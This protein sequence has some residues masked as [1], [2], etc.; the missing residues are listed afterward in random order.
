MSI[1]A[2]GVIDVL[3]EDGYAGWIRLPHHICKGLGKAFPSAGQIDPAM[4]Q[5]SFK[6]RIFYGRPLPAKSP[7]TPN[8]ILSSLYSKPSETMLE[9]D[10]CLIERVFYGKIPFVEAVEV[11]VI[12][13]ELESKTLLVSHLAMEGLA[14]SLSGVQVLIRSVSPASDDL[15][16]IGPQTRIIM[17]HQETPAIEFANKPLIGMLEDP[18]SSLD[19]AYNRLYEMVCYP[20]MHR[21]LLQGLPIGIPN[22]VILSGPPGVGKTHLVRRLAEA[23][24]VPALPVD[25]SN[26]MASGLGESESNLAKAFSDAISLADSNSTGMAILFLDEL[27]AIG[28]KREGASAVKARIVAQ[29]L[30]LM[31]G[32]ESVRRRNVVIIGATNRPNALDPALRRPGRFDREIIID[33]PTAMERHSL[34]GALAANIGKEESLDLE[35]ISKATIGYV[36]ADLSAL[37]REAVLIAYKENGKHLRLSTEH[38]IRAMRLVGPSLNRDYRVNLDPSL[39]LDSIGGYEDIKTRLQRWV[40]GPLKDPERYRLLG[41]GPPRGIL[42]HGPPGCSKTTFAKALAATAACTF[43][44]INGATA[45]SSLVGESERIVR[46]TFAM[47]RMT[48]P[49]IIFIDEIDAMVG[50]RGSGSGDVVQERILSTMLNEMDGVHTVEGRPLIVLGATNRLDCIDS[51]LLRPGR[52]DQI[53]EVALPNAAERLAIL[54]V[55]AKSTCMADDA[56]LGLLIGR[57]EGWSGAQLMALVQEAAM[58]AY[59]EDCDAVAMQHIEAALTRL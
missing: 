42:L 13:G 11:E 18:R 59:Q 45:F 48:A 26:I 27:D 35:A 10:E 29:L 20:V 28:A 25:A 49:A 38:L 7:Q 4:V 46:D 43:Y 12:A 2:P 51:A 44:S 30:T 14:I 19:F 6:D 22:G 54:H 32:S 58:A 57:T 16:L 17:A 47:A 33:P 52:F 8:V 40:L 3:E 15:G 53:L 37:Y 24:G 5:V 39:T 36:A 9:N 34:L 56:N 31:D 41:L 21:D 55:L 50:K 1:T 23:S